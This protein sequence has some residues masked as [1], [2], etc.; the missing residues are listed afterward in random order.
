MQEYYS[1]HKGHQS[2]INESSGEELRVCTPVTINGHV[3]NALVDTGARAGQ[4]RAIYIY[5]EFA[6][7]INLDIKPIIGKFSRGGKQ[8]QTAGTAVCTLANGTE[9]YTDMTLVVIPSLGYSVIL[10]RNVHTL[11]GFKLI[12]LPSKLPGKETS[13]EQLEIPEEEINILPKQD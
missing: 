8:D 7:T 12:G 1:L 6:R 5:E 2:Y 4:E 13:Q 10:G 11:M 9:T 3:A